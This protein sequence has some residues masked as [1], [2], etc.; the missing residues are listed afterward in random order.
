VGAGLRA[1]LF[2]AILRL[3]YTVPLSRGR[4]FRRGRWSLAFGEMF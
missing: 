1:N 2:F 4:D 3:D